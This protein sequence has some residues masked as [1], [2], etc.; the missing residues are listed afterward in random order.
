MQAGVHFL[1]Q[2]Q[3]V[4]LD[5]NS[6][7][8]GWALPNNMI[9]Y[10]VCPQDCD[11]PYLEYLQQQAWVAPA[12]W[13]DQQAWSSGGQHRAGMDDAIV[14]EDDGG[15]M[16][17]ARTPDDFEMPVPIS[18]N[19]SVSSPP[20]SLHFATFSGLTACAASASA[21]VMQGAIDGTA[22]AND[23]ALNDARY[24][25]STRND[26]SDEPQCLGVIL[27]NQNQWTLLSLRLAFAPTGCLHIRGVA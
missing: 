22:L 12:M 13:I 25:E 15:Q 1:Q 14:V 2:A 5:M 16:S 20:H 11:G 24:A 3:V 17:G 23:S 4:A 27:R 6:Y 7:P 26:L 9:G 19:F 21:P 10:S 8:G 18:P